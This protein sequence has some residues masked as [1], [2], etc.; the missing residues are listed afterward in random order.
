MSL[1]MPRV[2]SVLHFIPCF[3]N[4]LR[5]LGSEKEPCMMYDDWWLANDI[6]DVNWQDTTRQVLTAV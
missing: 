5:I 4:S 1:S 3:L 6:T 2:A